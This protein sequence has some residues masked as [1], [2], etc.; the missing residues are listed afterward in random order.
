MAL[1]IYKKVFA[2]F[3]AIGFPKTILNKI[4]IKNMKTSNLFCCLLLFFTHDILRINDDVNYHFEALQ[5]KSVEMPEH[6]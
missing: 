2:L 1:K 6:F 4:I 3:R 5:V